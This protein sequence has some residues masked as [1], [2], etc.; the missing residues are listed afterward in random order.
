MEGQLY[1]F[2]GNKVALM[3]KQISPSIEGFTVMSLLYPTLKFLLIYYF[4][5]IG[6]KMRENYLD[7]ENLSQTPKD[8][9]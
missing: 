4:S 7:P 5:I 3:P 9:K 1:W 2:K 6:I 8:A